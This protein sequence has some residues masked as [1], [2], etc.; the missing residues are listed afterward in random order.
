MGEATEQRAIR[1][2]DAASGAVATGPFTLAPFFGRCPGD[3]I[4]FDFGYITTNC[5][6]E[7]P[8][9]SGALSVAR[10]LEPI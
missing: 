1:A 10:Q 2:S 3:H 9:C 7:S 8:V 5:W 6:S 4:V